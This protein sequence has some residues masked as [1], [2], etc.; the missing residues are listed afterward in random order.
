ME[1]MEQMESMDPKPEME[2]MG[3]TAEV[4]AKVVMVAMAVAVAE[5]AVT[6]A[7]VVMLSHDA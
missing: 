3:L 1:P 2:L 5:M 4:V 6:E 7:K